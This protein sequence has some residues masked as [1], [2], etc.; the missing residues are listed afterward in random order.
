VSDVVEWSGTGAEWDAFADAAG[1]G[2]VSHLHAW[3]DVIAEVYGHRT[4]RLA[5]VADGRIRGVLPLV[6]MRRPLLPTRLVSMPYL[7]YGGICSAGDGCAETALLEA[8]LERARSESATLEL[9]HLR[10][11][12]LKLPRSDAKVTV[13]LPLGDDEDR[14]W[15]RLPGERRNRIRKARRAGLTASVCG[16]EALGA[17]FGVWS[18]NMRDLGS[19]PHRPGFFR[20][21]LRRLP[22]RSRL[23]TV[24][25]GERTVGAALL[26]RHRDVVSIP[27]VSSLRS[28][29]RKCP[30]Q[31]L[32]WEAMRWSLGAGARVLD[33]GR[34]SRG[35]G[36]LEAKRQWGAEPEPLD[37]HYHPET[38]AAPGDESRRFGWASA[39]WRR[40]PLPVANIVGTRLRGAIPN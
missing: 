32:Y 2:T 8:A 27:W 36:T 3:A 12:G 30:N 40:L 21:I 29:F 15:K 6:V 28:H 34:S 39:V 38:A 5:A 22:D 23:I 31:L 7:D 16:E 11:P 9:R 20:A 37:W 33:F 13:M 17:F 25:E 24:R 26:L 10:R 19:P 14:L 4:L 35:S 18:R 1:D